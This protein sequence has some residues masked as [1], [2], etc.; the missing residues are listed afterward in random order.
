MPRQSFQLSSTVGGTC[1]FNAGE[2]SVQNGGTPSDVQRLLEAV[3]FAAVQHTMQRRKDADSTPYI[4]HPIAVA[5][6]L[7]TFGGVSDPVTLMAAYLHDTIEDTGARAEKLEALFGAEIR[8]L[9]EEVSDDKGLPKDKRKELQ[10]AHAPF[11][12]DRAKQLKLA[13]LICNVADIGVRAP[14]GW[15][16]ERRRDYLDWAELVV[17]GCRGVNA[18]LEARFDAVLAD[19][20][21]EVSSA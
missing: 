6:V 16:V 14:Q 15:S 17:A 3:Q 7:N 2:F 21:R 9:V 12:S 1:G 19:A 20:R 13:D 5:A 8:R 18:G 4:N 10:I 11:L